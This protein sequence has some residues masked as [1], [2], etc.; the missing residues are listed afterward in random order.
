MCDARLFEAL[1]VALGVLVLERADVDEQFLL[2]IEQE[3]ARTGAHHRI[4]RHQ[5]RMREA[6]VDVLVDD[7]RLVQDQVALDQDRHLAVRVHHRDVFR[8]VEQ[9]DVA[10]LE[11]H[12]LF[13]QHETATM[14]E[15][16]GRARIKNHHVCSSLETKG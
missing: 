10:D 7:V 6:L 3:Q 5:L 12:A 8:L 2:E 14:G 4:G 9:V 16:A 15:W 13:E 1:L 11:I